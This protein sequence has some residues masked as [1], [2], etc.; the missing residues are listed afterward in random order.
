MNPPGRRWHWWSPGGGACQ[1]RKPGS[2]RAGYLCFSW[3]L[4][5]ASLAV[6]LYHLDP[7]ELHAPATSV[8]W[9]A[10]SARSSVT[11]RSQIR[12]VQEPE[13][14]WTASLPSWLLNPA[15]PTPGRYPDSCVTQQRQMQPDPRWFVQ[16]GS[17]QSLLLML[18]DAG[19]D[20]GPVGEPSRELPALQITANQRQ[21]MTQV[22]RRV[23]KHA[24]CT[25]PI[26]RRDLGPSFSGVSSKQ[27]RGAGGRLSVR[28][29]GRRARPKLVTKPVMLTASQRHRRAAG[30]NERP[31]SAS[32]HARRP[33]AG[34]AESTSRDYRVLMTDIQWG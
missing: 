14:H 5:G 7:R 3:Q 29:P 25:A 34:I 24:H 27:R 8:L 10:W 28:P 17:W 9:R 2:D 12:P 18:V 4:P 16:L 1:P 19:D 26:C 32:A 11:Q 20:G 30:S 6:R 31:R 33:G 22:S 13:R 23:T 21:E 15:V